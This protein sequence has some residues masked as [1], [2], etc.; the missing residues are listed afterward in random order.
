MRALWLI[1]IFL[2]S[3]CATPGTAGQDAAP[4]EDVESVP[5]PTAERTPEAQPQETDT[6]LMQQATFSFLLVSTCC[7]K[8]NAALIEAPGATILVDAGYPRD[9]PLA[10]DLLPMLAAVERFDLVVGT[11]PHQD[12]IGQLAD[13]LD[14]FEVDEVWM[15][16]STP[17]PGMHL[18]A[19]EAAAAAAGEWHEPRAGE[20]HHIGDLTVEV[21][22]PARLLAEHRSDDDLNRDSI[23]T[24]IT[25]GDVSVLLTGDALHSSE[26]EML[27]RD[28]L[29][30]TGLHGTVVITTDGTTFS[31]TTER[32]GAPIRSREDLVRLHESYAESTPTHGH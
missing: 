8:G 19:H 20:V 6:E 27:E 14:A 32:E 15:V 9:D 2:V 24:R 5:S 18:R 10:I 7:G 16:G 31:V 23:V 21:L 13:V 25:Y 28:A 3:A 11:H 17:P 29:Y 1:V 4:R 26:A 12:H 22:H 30:G